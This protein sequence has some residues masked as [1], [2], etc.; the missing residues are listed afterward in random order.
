MESKFAVVSFVYFADSFASEN[1][2]NFIISKFA[3]GQ[4]KLVE[5]LGDKWVND[6]TIVAKYVPDSG[7][8][9]GVTA[10][11]VTTPFRFY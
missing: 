1:L 7:V 5:E 10:V 9:N 4:E 8:K 2:V 3:M 11:R 6:M